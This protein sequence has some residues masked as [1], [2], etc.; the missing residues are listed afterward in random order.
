MHCPV[1]WRRSVWKT[2][3]PISSSLSQLPFLLCF[4]VFPSLPFPLAFPFLPLHPHP[5]PSPSLFFCPIF[6]PL[7][8]QFVP[9]R[10]EVVLGNFL[11]S[12]LPQ[13]NFN[14]FS[15]KDNWFIVKSFVARNLAQLTRLPDF[16]FDNPGQF[17]SP[18]LSPSW[19]ALASLK[20]FVGGP[21][22]TF[23]PY[24][25]RAIEAAFI[26]FRGLA[27]SRNPSAASQS[28]NGL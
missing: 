23:G 25:N 10:A 13:V 28:L 6:P 7:Q 17:L 27:P 21:W 5:L 2:A 16:H 18:F 11:N 14:A 22:G 3:G 4:F 15:D 1:Q 26:S 24:K 9:P 12:T 8:F 20:M 19:R